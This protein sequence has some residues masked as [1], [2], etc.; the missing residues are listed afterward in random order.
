MSRFYKVDFKL[1]NNVY[2]VTLF[3]RTTVSIFK[4]NLV[5]YCTLVL[6]KS[7]YRALKLTID[8]INRQSI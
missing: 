1:I 4:N 8:G 2:S 3:T 5:A 6:D 7:S